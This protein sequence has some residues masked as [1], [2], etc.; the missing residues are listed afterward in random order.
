MPHGLLPR[1]LHGRR[2]QKGMEKE[3]KK[4]RVTRPKER[5]R[6]RSQ[7]FVSTVDA[8]VIKRKIAG[9]FGKLAMQTHQQLWL[10]MPQFKRV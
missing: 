1:L 9:E 6:Q 4:A 3:I 10:Q 2:L 5:E 7:G 8:L